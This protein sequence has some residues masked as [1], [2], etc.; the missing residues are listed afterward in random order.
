MAY[1]KNTVL[2]LADGLTSL[3]IPGATTRTLNG[4]IYHFQGMPYGMI[5]GNRA[6]TNDAGQIVY[7]RATGI[8]VQS[9]LVPLGK[10]VPPLTMGFSNTFS[11]KDFSLGV[12]IDG[13]FGAQVYSATNAFATEFGLDKRTVANGIRETGIAV[14]GVDQQGAP[15][16]GN[17]SAQT[18]YSTI[19][20]TLT[21]QFVTDA[22]FIKLRQ[23]TFSY[24]IPKSLLGHTP[25]QSAT[26][27]L[28][29]RNLLFIHN[30]A[31]NIDPESSYSNGNAQGLENFGLPTTRS[32]GFNLSVRF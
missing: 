10:G 27:S 2:K 11:Y 4:G 20:S 31:R 17:V 26:F 22:D 1:N 16:S 14:S 19:W 23:V 8:P 9:P 5:A 21:D 32:Y 12:L 30:S 29:G 6:L 18:Y 13:K 7:N 25:I 15:Y 3:F 28:V 24:T